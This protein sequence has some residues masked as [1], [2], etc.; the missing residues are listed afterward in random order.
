M[1]TVHHIVTMTII[2]VISAST[3]AFSQEN[4]EETNARSLSIG[5]GFP[6][7]SQPF[8]T[9]IGLGVG[10]FPEYE[11]SDDYAATALPLINIRKTGAYFIK[12][13]SININDGLASVGLTLLHFSYSEE[14]KHRM[15]IVMGP[16]MRAYSG[17]YKSDSDSLNGLGDIDQSVGIGGFIELSAGAWLANLSVSPQD[18]IGRA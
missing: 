11:G 14:S 10:A 13:S 18:E 8:Q 4:N 1:K 15:Q 17:R 2:A 5:I 12:G 16:L 7:N 3:P 9:Q 6:D